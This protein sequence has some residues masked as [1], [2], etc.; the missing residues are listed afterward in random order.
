M[1]ETIKTK[2]NSQYTQRFTLT[3]TDENGNLQPSNI[4]GSSPTIYVYDDQQN[5][6][7]SQA[8]QID[9]A[10]NGKFSFLMLSDYTKR[11]GSFR[12]NIFATYL[13][14]NNV[15]WDDGIFLVND[16]G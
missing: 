9:D 1:G 14:G 7:F 5:L 12:Y 3:Q 10:I 15:P 4:T 8:C 16:L 11:P 2:K 13:N 6:I